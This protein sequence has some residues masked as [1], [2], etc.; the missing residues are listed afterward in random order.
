MMT[1]RV[2]LSGSAGD[3]G[4]ASDHAEGDDVH[5]SDEDEQG[6]RHRARAAAPAGRHHR[7]PVAPGQAAFVLREP[8]ERAGL[9]TRRP[10]PGPRG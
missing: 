4:E 5:E 8:G 1:T 2:N 10:P 7:Q 9:L 6:D 3:V